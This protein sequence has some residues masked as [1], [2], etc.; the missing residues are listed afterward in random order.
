MDA[1]RAVQ[2]QV[3]VSEAEARAALEHTKGNITEAILYLYKV[4]PPPPKPK[5]EWDERRELCADF[6]GSMHQFVLQH[7]RMQHETSTGD[8]N[9][10]IRVIPSP[11]SVEK[12]I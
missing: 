4:P 5:T 12:R 9:G 3:D 2:T 11:A 6:E 8:A 10:A 1:I 7:S